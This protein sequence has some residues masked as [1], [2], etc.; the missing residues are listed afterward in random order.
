MDD[1]VYKY[2]WIETDRAFA[3]SKADGAHI[4]PKAMC[5]EHYTWLDKVNFNQ[6]A[7][8]KDAHV[9]FNGTARGNAARAETQPK[10]AIEPVETDEITI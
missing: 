5:K 3:R 10:V 6:L 4:F 2:Q 7:L 8:S 9:N 1:T